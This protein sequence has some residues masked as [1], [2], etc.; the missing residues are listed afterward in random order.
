M[1]VAQVG[2]ANRKLVTPP[3]VR[4]VVENRVNLAPAGPSVASARGMDVAPPNTSCTVSES[5][6]LMLP[7]G[8][9]SGATYQ[10]TPWM[11]MKSR[12]SR[13]PASEM[14]AVTLLYS[15]LFDSKSQKRLL[16]IPRNRT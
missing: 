3:V 4:S 15:V 14:S 10:P 8:T 12:K 6:W 13:R 9:S 2:A 11:S 7:T 5:T 1:A 16:G